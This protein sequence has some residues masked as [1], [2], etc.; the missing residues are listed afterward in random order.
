MAAE[1][2]IPDSLLYV[3]NVNNWEWYIP[4]LSGDPPPVVPYYH[5]SN[6]IGKYMVVTW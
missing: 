2:S 1:F 3:L 6:V 5:R 4:N